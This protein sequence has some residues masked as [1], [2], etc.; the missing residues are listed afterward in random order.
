MS[1]AA[2]YKTTFEKKLNK[3]GST[4]AKLRLEEEGAKSTISSNCTTPG[5]ILSVG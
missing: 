1:E 5:K 3:T 4:L 2:E